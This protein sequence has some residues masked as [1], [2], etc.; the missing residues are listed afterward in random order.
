MIIGH[1]NRRKKIRPRASWHCKAATQIVCSLPIDQQLSMVLTTLYIINVDT[2]N[3]VWCSL[4]VDYEFSLNKNIVW[5]SL[6][7]DH[8]IC[9]VVLPSTW[10]EISLVLPTIW[11]AA[12]V[13]APRHRSNLV[14]CPLQQ[15]GSLGLVLQVC[16]VVPTT[17]CPVFSDSGVMNTNKFFFLHRQINA[18]K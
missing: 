5:S 4:I 13:C 9:S 12:L 14:S 2:Y 7:V 11:L 6:L 18:S 15:G 1:K 3:I 10:S 16:L 8:K 17:T